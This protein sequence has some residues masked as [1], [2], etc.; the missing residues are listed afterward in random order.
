M[1][2]EAFTTLVARVT[3]RVAGRPLD[4]SLESTFRELLR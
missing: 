2:P 3:A 1:T 4:A